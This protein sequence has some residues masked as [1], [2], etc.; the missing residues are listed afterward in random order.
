MRALLRSS[1]RVPARAVGECRHTSA[2]MRTQLQS[3]VCELLRME[4]KQ[5]RMMASRGR[6]ALPTQVHVLHRD[7][8]SPHVFLRHLSD[9]DFVSVR[10]DIRLIGAMPNN[11]C[12]Q[13]LRMTSD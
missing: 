3:R 9:G 2:H 12:T 10:D 13:V 6:A 5:G 7:N 8:A 4:A 11:K 1:C